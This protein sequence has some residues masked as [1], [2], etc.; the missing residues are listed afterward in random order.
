MHQIVRSGSR[1]QLHRGGWGPSGISHLRNSHFFGS[2]PDE[3]VLV[4]HFFVKYISLERERGFAA[5]YMFLCTSM[6]RSAPPGVASIGAPG[7]SGVIY[8]ARDLLYGASAG[9]PFYLIYWI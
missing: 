8:L 3:N 6:K 1:A 5:I 7:S 2:L 4:G 9:K